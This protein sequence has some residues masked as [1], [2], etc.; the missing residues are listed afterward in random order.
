MKTRPK[1]IPKPGQVDFTNIR[2]A[3]VVNCV[4]EYEGSFL[5]VKRSQE[6]RL[7]PN[8]W[9]GISGF[10]DDDQCL[11]EK[12]RNEIKEELGL[13]ENDVLEIRLGQIFDQDEPKYKKTW[14]VHPVHVK[15]KTD[16]ITLDWEAANYKWLEFSEIKDL[17]LLPGFDLV[18]KSLFPES[19]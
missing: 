9:N 12:V 6:L 2:W 5:L 19:Y 11:E 1:F 18:L 10:L 3:P 14:I 15:V 8:F 13:D 4:V 7:Y 16:K 17:D